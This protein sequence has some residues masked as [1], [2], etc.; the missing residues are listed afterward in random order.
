LRVEEL[1]NSR[2]IDVAD[3]NPLCSAGEQQNEADRIAQIVAEAP[4]LPLNPCLTPDPRRSTL[5]QP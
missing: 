2:A 1:K 3:V 4:G 5:A